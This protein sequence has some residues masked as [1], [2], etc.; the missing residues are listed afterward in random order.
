[1][2][3]D[4]N[5]IAPWQHVNQ[6]TKQALPDGDGHRVKLVNAA[7]LG[8]RSGMTQVFE[9]CFSH[10]VHW[11]VVYAA[12]TP[13]SRGPLL[14]K[15]FQAVIGAAAQRLPALQPW[16]GPWCVDE[17]VE[18]GLSGELVPNV[19]AERQGGTVIRLMATHANGGGVDHQIRLLNPGLKVWVSV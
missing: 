9:R 8:G 14:H 13:Q 18:H 19:H 11:N 12:P 2:L 5:G 16:R 3:T 7:R 10:R 15:H 17:V 6:Q 1:M 4:G